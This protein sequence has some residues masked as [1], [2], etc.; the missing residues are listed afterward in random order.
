MEPA[1]GF[2]N[3]INLEKITLPDTV[4]TISEFAFDGCTNITEITIPASVTSIG[5]KVFNGCSNLEN[6][7]FEATTGWSTGKINVT[8]LI[9]YSTYYS[10][11]SDKTISINFSFDNTFVNSSDAANIY[12]NEVKFKTTVT[13]SSS[14][15]VNNYYYASICLNNYAI[16]RN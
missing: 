14:L 13:H 7:Y 8:P 10:V 9:K 3:S 6:I 1:N 4:T 5:E 15:A 2:Q 16:Y 12:L 11:V